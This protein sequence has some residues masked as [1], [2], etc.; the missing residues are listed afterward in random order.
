MNI[1]SKEARPLKE[2]KGFQKVFLKAG[3][4][5]EITF[6]IT[7][8]LLKYYNYELQYVAEPGAFDLMIGMDS[9]HVKNSNICAA[10]T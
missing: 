1:A 10:L 2:L 7:P 5:R 9:Q 6:K 4:S 8:D 3:E